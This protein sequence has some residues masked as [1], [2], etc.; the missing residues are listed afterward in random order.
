MKI[1]QVGNK[2]HQNLL[3]LCEC[4]RWSGYVWRMRWEGQS[5]DIENEL[6]FPKRHGGSILD[7]KFFSFLISFFWFSLFFLIFFQISTSIHHTK[8]KKKL[9]NRAQKFL[10]PWAIVTLFGPVYEL[11]IISWENWRDEVQCWRNIK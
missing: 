5:G 11:L 9:K 8:K 10:C 3:T 2:K 4:L 1:I 6:S 7:L